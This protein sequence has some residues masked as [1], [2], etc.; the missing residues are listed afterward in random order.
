MWLLLLWLWWIHGMEQC[1]P[2]RP[3]LLVSHFNW[4]DARPGSIKITCH[5]LCQV[6]GPFWGLEV[7]LTQLKLISIHLT[8]WIQTNETINLSKE[9]IEAGKWSTDSFSWAVESE[10]LNKSPAGRW[11]NKSAPV[12]RTND[13][14]TGHQIVRSSG[15]RCKSAST[16]RWR[17]AWKLAWPPNL[18][19][20]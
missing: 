13:D 17:C 6:K 1:D 11:R 12:T 16:T 20:I 8:T 7:D 15:G 9:V 18:N 3:H 14:A 2:F 19:G 5:K 4:A 10:N